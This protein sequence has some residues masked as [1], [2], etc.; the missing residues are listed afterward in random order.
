MSALGCDFAQQH[1]LVALRIASVQCKENPAKPLPFAHDDL[2]IFLCLL[3][4]RA[5]SPTEGRSGRRI[6][7]AVERAMQFLQRFRF[8]VWV[9]LRRV[10]VA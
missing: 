9:T 5:V 8:Y 6:Y 3:L 4:G 2:D 1:L 10:K 7:P